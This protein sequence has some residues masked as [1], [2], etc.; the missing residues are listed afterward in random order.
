MNCLRVLNLLSAYIDRELSP[1]DQ[2]RISRH[3][4]VCSACRAELQ[5]LQEVKDALSAM[6]SLD[7]PVG[8]WAELDGKLAAVDHEPVLGGNGT[9]APSRRDAAGS[10]GFGKWF[11]LR[12][13][14]PVGVAAAT[15]LLLTGQQFFLHSGGSGSA[16]VQIT[17][18]TADGR[19][20]QVQTEVV[21]VDSLLREH[22]RYAASDPLVDGVSQ[23]YALPGRLG[24]Y[25]NRGFPENAAIPAGFISGTAKW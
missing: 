1:D 9:A 11:H 19:A 7:L 16:A 14:I 8:F 24:K 22:Y 10:Y 20:G 4:A 6:P 17:G 15:L 23:N 3:L 12:R 21:P 18:F 2:R 25:L 5:S 13:F